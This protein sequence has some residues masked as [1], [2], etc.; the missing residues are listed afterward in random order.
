LPHRITGALHIEPTRSES[1]LVTDAS[2]S[3][4]RWYDRCSGLLENTSYP[5]PRFGS[6]EALGDL[7]AAGDFP[8]A[9]DLPLKR[10]V[11]CRTT[12]LEDP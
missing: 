4:R 12:L 2:S 1:S 9:C 10:N 3:E 11:N 6:A 5:R 7:S 8:K